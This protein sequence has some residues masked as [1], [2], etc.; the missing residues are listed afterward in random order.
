[1]EHVDEKILKQREMM[2]EFEKQRFDKDNIEKENQSSIFDGQIEIH[3]IPV[4]FAE[5][6]L[7]DDRIAIWMP[8]DFRELT[9]EEINAVYL[10]GNKPDVVYGNAYLN[11]SL[12]FHY[13]DNEVPN[14]YMGDFVKIARMILEK[15]GPKVTVYSE[16]VRKTGYHTVSSLELV[17]HTITDTI[18][19]VMFYSSLNGKVLIG[20]LNFN[21]RYLD[22]YKKIAKEMLESFRFIEDSRKEEE[23]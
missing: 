14:E 19:N 18:Y 10:L 12:G 17:S 22:R 3:K 16:K 13:T 20:F 6:S 23:G 5:R 9:Q 2:E 15:S 8:E 7:L 21:Y 4:S 11:L 1:M